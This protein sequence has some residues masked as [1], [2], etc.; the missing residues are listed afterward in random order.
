MGVARSSLER[1]AVIGDNREARV[2]GESLPTFFADE[3]GGQDDGDDAEE[4]DSPYNC[5]K[6]FLSGRERLRP[7]LLIRVLCLR[8]LPVC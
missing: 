3:K 6:R 7:V 5:I 4:C 2:A 8:R 1:G